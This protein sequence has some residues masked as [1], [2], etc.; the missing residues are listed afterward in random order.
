MKRLKGFL[1]GALAAT[2]LGAAAPAQAAE[3]GT[4][5]ILAPWQSSGQVYRVGETD[6][7]FN[8]AAEG[9]MYIESGEGALDAAV[10]MCPG[11]REMSLETGKSVAHGR[12]IITTGGGD[13]VFAMYKCEGMAGDCKGEF[14]LTGGTGAFKGISGGGE[15]LVR[16]ALGEMVVDLESGAAVRGAAGLAVWPSLKYKLPK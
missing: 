7:L 8:G 4:V 1:C 2:V 13:Q 9:I 10:M 3:E 15:M 16:T 11:S 6:L 12:C 5:K 14:T